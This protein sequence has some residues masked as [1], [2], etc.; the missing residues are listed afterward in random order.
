[1]KKVNRKSV[2]SEHNIGGKRRNFKIK[3]IVLTEIFMDYIIYI[4]IGGMLLGK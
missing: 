2:K 1:M 4:P 3:S